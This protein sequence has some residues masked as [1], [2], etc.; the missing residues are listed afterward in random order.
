MNILLSVNGRLTSFD[1]AR[2][3]N[4]A[5]LLS[6]LVTSYPKFKVNEWG[7]P[8]SK[9]VSLLPLGILQRT[10]GKLPDG[11]GKKLATSLQCLSY[12]YLA[13][14]FIAKDVDILDCWSG[15]SLNSIKKARS[16]GAKTV[17]HRGSSHIEYQ[18]KI[19][20]DEYEKAGFLYPGISQK[21][22][23]TELAEYRASDYVC[24]P[25]SFA[26]RSFIDKGFADEKILQVPYGVDLS[27]FK[28]TEKTDNIFRFVHCGGL[29]IRKGVHF[30]LEAF[31]DLNL[32]NSELLLIGG[33]SKE[34]AVYL[35]KFD[36]GSVVLKNR[37]P[38]N[39]LHKY[40]SQGSVFCLASVEEGLA[41]VQA[42]AMA[43]G[44]PVICTKNTGGEDIVSD[45]KSGFVIEN[46]DVGALKE[47]M[48]FLYENHSVCKEMSEV[49]IKEVQSNSGW[50]VYGDRMIKIYQ[51]ILEQKQS[52]SI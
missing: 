28:R 6:T 45:G 47:K 18:D 5:G 51:D 9:I 41:L 2:E 15:S 4:K 16:L 7:I 30:L 32:P 34:I 50:G 10:I 46:A 8:N 31:F 52:A 38:F 13:S 19:L 20:R 25:S 37:V 22:I 3:L 49:A 27:N 40:Y 42:Q 26:R 48:L 12:D 35:K 24:V 14:H 36:N 1:L 33:L 39:D 23:D 17:L 29:T 21:N 44:L 43:C 11:K